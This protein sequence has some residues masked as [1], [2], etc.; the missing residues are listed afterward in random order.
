MSP[1]SNSS[2]NKSVSRNP[3][4]VHTNVVSNSFV[5]WHNRLGH[6]HPNAVKNV[7]QLCNIPITNKM[8]NDF[9][10][11]CCLGKSYKL[12]APPSTTLQTTAFEL[13]HSDLWGPAPFTSSNGYN[14][15][16][17]FVYA[18]CRYTWIYFRKKKSEALTAFKQFHALVK[19]HYSASIKAFQSDWGG[20]LRPFTNHLAE[21]G[22]IHMLTC[23]H[24]SHQNGTV[25]RK[26][27]QIVEMGLTLLSHAS[28]PLTYWDHS[29]IHLINRL[30]QQLL[31][32]F[33]LL[34]IL[35]KVLLSTTLSLE[36]LVVHA[37]LC[38]VLIINTSCSSGDKMC[39]PWHFPTT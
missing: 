38:C 21:L 3:A 37:F 25:E 31:P 16:I 12:Y 9:C 26:H 29:F 28:M 33:L 20:E 32:H 22:I 11:A 5:T 39:V 1:H 36:P 6:A 14:Y 35:S 8:T 7:L 18:F 10:N 24:T 19:T 27:R 2:C 17:A 13:I 34:I 4:T 23:P 30:P 15:Y